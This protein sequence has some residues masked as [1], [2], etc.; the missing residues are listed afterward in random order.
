VTFQTTQSVGSGRELHVTRKLSCTKTS[1][2]KL[3][4]LPASGRLTMTLPAP[5]KP[6]EI[7]Y[8]RAVL[9]FS[10]GM[11]YSLPIEVAATS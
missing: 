9:P 11:T 7:T 8:Y 6:G 10:R 1:I 5:T 2:Y 4:Q 3:V